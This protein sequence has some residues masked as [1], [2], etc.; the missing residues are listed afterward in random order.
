MGLLGNNNVLKGFHRGRKR[1][2]GS[3]IG[4]LGKIDVL[5]GLLGRKGA[6]GSKME[7]LGKIDFLEGFFV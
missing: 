1:A 5:K 2:F 3:K 6:F 4:L 7:L